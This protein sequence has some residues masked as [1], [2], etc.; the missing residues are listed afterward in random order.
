M[1]DESPF[2]KFDYL[3]SNVILE[4]LGCIPKILAYQAFSME[5]VF[6]SVSVYPH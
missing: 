5:S 6:S 3:E 2:H 4:I 1:N